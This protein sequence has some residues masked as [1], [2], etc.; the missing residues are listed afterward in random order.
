MKGAIGMD[1]AIADSREGT[2]TTNDEVD[3]LEDGIEALDKKVVEATENRKE[4]NAVYAEMMA[5]DAAELEQMR[6]HRDIP[7]T[8]PEDVQAYSKKTEE[9]NGVIAKMHSRSKDLDE[10]EAQGGHEE[11][12]KD[13]GPPCYG[14][15]G[16]IRPAV[17]PNVHSANERCLKSVTQD[18]PTLQAVQDLQESDALPAPLPHRVLQ[19][20]TRAGEQRRAGTSVCILT[21]DQVTGTARQSLPLL[22]A[23]PTSPMRSAP[24]LALVQHAL[25]ATQ[26]QLNVAST[27]NNIRRAR[28]AGWPQRLKPQK[29][30]GRPQRL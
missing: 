12:M 5:S 23:G 4:E 30:M 20:S 14:P 26:P 16:G 28:R 3:A 9:S 13:N 27:T 7:L 17:E 22:L 29:Q 21:Y 6:A 19:F 11:M 25:S 10:K 2:S 1:T 24:Q 8:T 15:W 18:L